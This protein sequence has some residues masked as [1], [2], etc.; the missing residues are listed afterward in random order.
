MTE[1]DSPSRNVVDSVD[2]NREGHEQKDQQQDQAARENHAGDLQSDDLARKG[3]ESKE[4]P[5]DPGEPG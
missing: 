4:R 2:T 5:E 3:K 1:N